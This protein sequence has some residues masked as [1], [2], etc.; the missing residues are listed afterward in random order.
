MLEDC[1][2]IG[3]SKSP[4]KKENDRVNYCYIHST[5]LMIYGTNSRNKI[6]KRQ[7]YAQIQI[8]TDLQNDPLN[9]A[10][11]YYYYNTNVLL[12]GHAIGMIEHCLTNTDINI[13]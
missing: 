11:T 3:E 8:I 7:I 4:G 1:K 10:L 13:D 6:F 12:C 5:L 9:S 2:Y